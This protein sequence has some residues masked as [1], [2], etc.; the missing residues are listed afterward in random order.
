MKKIFIFSIIVIF[1]VMFYTFS[2]NSF[3]LPK[4]NILPN[5][6][7]EK[8]YVNSFTIYGR[9][10]NLE[11]F[12]PDK[13]DNLILVLKN[14]LS[15]DEYNLI[16][17][18]DNEQTN[19]KTN[20]LINTGIN[21]ENILEGEYIILLKT[22]KDEETI[23][24]NLINK[25]KYSD[26]EYY[27][28]TKNNSNNKIDITFNNYLTL[29]N[30]KTKLPSDY[31]DIIID[32]G[33]GGKDVGANKNGYYE[34]KINLEYATKLKK[35]LENIGYKVKLTR[36]KDVTLPN[37]GENSR[38]SVPYET[39]AKLM[40]SI[41]QNSGVGK[42]NQGGF[43]VYV[44]NHTNYDFGNIL[45]KNIQKYTS[46]PISKNVSYK[47]APG[48]Y[49]RT[50]NQSDLEEIKKDALKNNYIPYEKATLDSTYY[51]MIREVGG[52]ITN[53]YVDSRNPEKPGNIYYDSNHGTEAYLLELG[54]INSTSN[55]K[56]ILEEK[57]KFVEAITTS[58]KEYLENN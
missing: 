21:L 56:I 10:F 49:L 50:L 46:S 44:V 22:I 18:Y 34:S 54:Y 43:E 12:I 7:Y 24:Y 9:F 27:T 47:I 41:H 37:Y 28:L 3:S 15:E 32:P 29:T 51:F 5:D 58:V 16:T 53:S 52:I 1:L 23:Y 45:V 33:H 31:Y 57:D 48:V 38:V 11:G 40:L 13:V 20:D 2:K 19:F 26:L 36:D 39:K 17:N 35:S 30:K 55:L 4:N 8:A 6:N 14:D 25:T 42:I